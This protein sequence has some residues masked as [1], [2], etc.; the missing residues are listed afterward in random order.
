MNSILTL[1][2]SNGISSIGILEKTCFIKHN[3]DENYHKNFM[4]CNGDFMKINQIYAF[5]S[6]NNMELYILF[7]HGN[8]QVN[9]QFLTE[10]EMTKNQCVSIIATDY[11]G[12][13]FQFMNANYKHPFVYISYD[14][15]IHCYRAK[16]FLGMR[17]HNNLMK[18]I[19][20]KCKVSYDTCDTQE[21]T[22]KNIPTIVGNSLNNNK[23]NNNILRN[24]MKIEMGEIVESS[25]PL[26]IK[27]EF[28]ITDNDDLNLEIKL[29][30]HNL[31]IIGE[32][33]DKFHEI[34]YSIAKQLK[35]LN[36]GKDTNMKRKRVE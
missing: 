24:D 7:N 28:I 11:C 23:Q 35:T 6:A 4:S 19:L 34:A 12:D 32:N 29:D 10:F 30:G 36:E 2:G 20:T 9:S 31:T 16:S 27:K 33:A 21:V 5:Y 25:K 26:R 8:I 18:I 22:C 14:N 15:T 1:D 3:C 17:T 13:T